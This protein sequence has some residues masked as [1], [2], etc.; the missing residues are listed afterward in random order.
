MNRPIASLGN[1]QNYR[2]NVQK[3]LTAFMVVHLTIASAASPA[4]GTAQSTGKFR[5]DNSP[6]SGNATLFEGSRIETASSSPHVDIQNGPSFQLAPESRATIF[7]NRAVLEQGGA[8]V[9]GRPAP[10]AS[11]F[12]VQARNLWIQTEDQNGAARIQ[13]SGAT[14][15]QVAAIKGTIRVKNAQ[16]LLVANLAAGTALEF[17]P[18]NGASGSTRMS[19]CLHKNSNRFMLTDETTSVTVELRG[20]GLDREVG[21]NVVVNGMMEA[22]GESQIVHVASIA[23]GT[24]GC[25]NRAGKAA[26]T[27]GVGGA[28]STG[29]AI[30]GT[31]IAIVGGVAAAA[32]VGGLAATN[33]LPGQSAGPTISK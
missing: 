4:I 16:G 15:V 29:W 2:G 6:V 18:Q 8:I 27:A 10:S 19:G 9:E 21:H 11:S 20:E 31:T 26:A 12:G 33:S 13:L 30:S 32:T 7:G 5:V 3:M 25:S 28:V 24:K 17:D 22:A 23:R 1:V 14:R